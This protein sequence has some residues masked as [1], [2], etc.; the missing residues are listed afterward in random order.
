VKS[1]F[2]TF[3]LVY[4]CGARFGSVKRQNLLWAIHKLSWLNSHN[5][6]RLVH[7]ASSL[8]RL[9]TAI[10]CTMQV[11]Y[12]APSVYAYGWRWFSMYLEQ[13]YM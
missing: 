13:K 11:L 5:A 7:L 1:V 3:D 6:L 2:F 9:I 12:E 8:F 10:I 4:S